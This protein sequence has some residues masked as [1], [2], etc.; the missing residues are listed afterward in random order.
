MAD[1]VVTDEERAD[2]LEVF[3]QLSGNQFSET[4][5]TTAETAAIP[6]DS[7]DTVV[8]VGKR[9][10]FTGTF[11]FGRREKCQEAVIALGAQCGK[12]VTRD[13]DYFVIGTLPSP[14][15]KHKSFGLKIGRALKI[16]EDGY[17]RP[18]ILS[19]KQWVAALQ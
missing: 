14:D 4:G 7:P 9:F 12:D 5:S 8:F 15:W 16:R 11:T 1:G 2:L 6:F 17:A 19:E 13:T 18:L 3:Q 10:C